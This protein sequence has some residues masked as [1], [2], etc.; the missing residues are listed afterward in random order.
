M[1]LTRAQFLKTVG[2]DATFNYKLPLEE[3]LKE[4]ASVTGGKFSR[5]FDASAMASQ[6]GMEALAQHGDPKVEVKH[7]A[8]TNDW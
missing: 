5:V 1:M 8:T 3:Q 4:I 2:A 6:T 7:F